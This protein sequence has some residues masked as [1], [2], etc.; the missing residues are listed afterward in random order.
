M[1]LKVGAAVW[2]LGMVLYFAPAHT[3]GQ[4]ITTGPDSVVVPVAPVDTAEAE[5]RGF[6][7][8]TWDRPAKAALFSAIVPG[9]GQIYNKAYWKLPI[10]YGTGAVLTYFL[11]DNNTKYQD[12]K[13]AYVQRVD[14]DPS[15]IDK[16]AN[17]PN[18]PSLNE[19][20]GAE[21][22]S[23]LK[24]RYEYYRRNR[25]LT[26]IL[27]VAAYSLQ[28]AEAYVHAHLREFDVGEDLALRVQPNLLHL[29]AQPGSFTPGVSFTLY[30][31][32]SK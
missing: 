12:Y 5:K 9:G 17:D 28:I 21:A 29:Q 16:Y 30:T 3:H 8:S 24:Y 2:L 23:N 11:I 20:R 19:S 10:V 7:L 13:K 32:S 22:E 25:D 18:F 14:R 6:F 26:I 4:V 31:R 27:S 15:T 1:R